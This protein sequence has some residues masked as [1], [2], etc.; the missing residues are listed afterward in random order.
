M[1]D[2]PIGKGRGLTATELALAAAELAPALCGAEVLDASPIVDCDD[3]LLVLQRE[4]HYRLYW[5]VVITKLLC[6]AC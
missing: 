3:L 1:T 5:Y 2:A 6:A 4:D